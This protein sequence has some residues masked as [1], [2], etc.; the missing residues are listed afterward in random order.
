MK[1]KILLVFCLLL[2]VVQKKNFAQVI[3]L[4]FEQS[5]ADLMVRLDTMFFTGFS[6]SK[7]HIVQFSSESQF[8]SS[9]F[10]IFILVGVDKVWR[11]LWPKFQTSGLGG[12]AGF[13]KETKDYGRSRPVFNVGGFINISYN[14][15]SPEVFKKDIYLNIFYRPSFYHFISGNGRGPFAGLDEDDNILWHAFGITL[16]I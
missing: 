10:D 6:F 2:F 14:I 7:G 16:G 3:K 9:S 4:P 1:T 5:G 8:E 11:G 15:V 12:L 13:L